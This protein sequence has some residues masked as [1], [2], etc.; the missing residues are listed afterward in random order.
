MIEEREIVNECY[1]VRERVGEDT[2][3]EWWRASAIFVA[4]NFL[5]RFVKDGFI[6][7]EATSKAF[8]E[9]ARKRINIVSPAILSL[10]EVDRH[11]KQFFIAS[12]YDGH[13]NLRSV[14]DSGRRFTVEHACRLII[15]LAEGVGTFHLRD[16]AFGVL[17]PEGIVV[18]GFADRIDEIKLL[19]PSYETFFEAIPETQVEEFKQTWGYASPE[20]KRGER[21]SQKSDLYSLGVLLFRLLTGKLPYGSRSGILVRTRSA[22]PAHVAAALARRGIPRE[23]AMTT[24]R[25]LRKK[26]E[27]R[28][29]D[30]MVF[31]TELRSILDVRREAWIKSGKV[32]P[33]ADLA[34]LNLKKAKADAHEIVRSLE[35]VNYFRFLGDAGDVGELSPIE[36]IEADE[37]IIEL[38]EIEAI[39]GEDDDSISTEAYV[40]AGYRTAENTVHSRKEQKKASIVIAAPEPLPPVQAPAKSMAAEVPYTAAPA[41]LPVQTYKAAP[42]V[43]EKPPMVDEPKH[44]EEKRVAKSSSAPVYWKHSGGSPIEVAEKLTEAVTL[45]AAGNGIVRFIQEPDS[46][47]SARI[48]A[49]ALENLRTTTLL[50]DLGALPSGATIDQLIELVEKSLGSGLIPGSKTRDPSAAKRPSLTM[51][52]RLLARQAADSVVSRADRS[53]PLVMI[54]RGTSNVSPSAHR[55]FVELASRAIHAPV[56]AFLFFSA[57][58][59]PKWHVLSSMQRGSHR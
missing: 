34:T 1:I 12:E 37:E 21:G 6:T 55:F 14:L 33:I 48:V 18:H 9:I 52:T 54:A 23:L 17:T 35:T 30:I 47:E 43:S 13:K 20:F 11:G 16:E 5:L 38:E 49:E 58:A 36:T 45:A 25:A 7:D 41:A 4:S 26:P 40:D 51:A 39:Q 29:S 57:G 22:S 15:E 8:L 10:V 32:D 3:S 46:G 56:C 42:V 27:L 19:L 50:L 44:P 53:R 31:I 28:H 2:F 59:V 24:V